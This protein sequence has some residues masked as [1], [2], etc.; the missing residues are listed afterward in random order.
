MARIEQYRSS[1]TKRNTITDSDIRLF[2][3]E[4]GQKGDHLE[5]VICLT[6]LGVEID[7]HDYRGLVSTRQLEDIRIA[8]DMQ[9]GDARRLCVD[10]IKQIKQAKKTK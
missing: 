1:M 3:I 6:A 2:A 9:T 7:Y 4:S 5:A 8:A 10:A